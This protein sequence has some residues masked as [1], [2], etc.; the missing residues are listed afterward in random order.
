HSPFLIDKNHSERIRVLEKGEHDEGTRVVA[1]SSRN[2]YEPLR[3]AL[4]SFVGETA[5][6]G[7]C[8]LLLEGA[9]DQVL[10]AGVSRWLGRRGAPA[11]ERL[12]LNHLTLVPAGSASHIPYL[13]FLARARDVDTP[14]VI[15]LLDGDQP[16]TDARAELARGGP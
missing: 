6:I 10:V 11:T 2:H 8:N 5:F 15:V 3:S 13:A 7:T 12:D 9:S 1:N 14:P 4:G 16:G